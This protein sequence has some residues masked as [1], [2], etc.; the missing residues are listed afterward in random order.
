MESL[1][2]YISNWIYFERDKK[3]IG[4]GA[5][6]YSTTLNQYLINVWNEV[7]EVEFKL[8]F[9]KLNHFYVYVIN[10]ENVISLG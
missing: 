3:C 1:Y 2:I 10:L 5:C 9:W 6:Q 7:I 8:F 4:S